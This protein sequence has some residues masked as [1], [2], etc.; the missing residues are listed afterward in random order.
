MFVKVYQLYKNS[1]AGLDRNSWLLALV[2]LVNRSGTMVVPFMSMYMTQHHGV[3]LSKAGVVMACFGVG[4]ITGSFIGGKLTDRHGFYKTMILTLFLGG[5]SFILLSLLNNYYWICFGTFLCSLINEAFRPASMTAIGAY[6]SAENMTRSS[7]LVR[8]SVNLGWALGAALGGWLASYHYHLLFWVDGITNIAASFL[9]WYALPNL[10]SSIKKTSISSSSTSVFISAYKDKWFITFVG[11][12]SLFAICFFQLFTT[13]PV[14]L[15]QEMHLSEA[16]IGTALAFN[17]LIILVFEMV[18]VYQLRYK[19]PVNLI[20]IGVLLTGLSFV[21]FN[22][23]PFSAILVSI[24]S[25][26]II[27]IGEIMSMPFMLT[28]TLRRGDPSTRGQYAALYT[29]AY[30]IAHIIGSSGGSFIADHYGFENLWWLIGLLS[31]AIAL[32]FLFLK[33]RFQA[34]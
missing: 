17:G 1:F 13:L 33:P 26:F 31:L 5:M 27:S 8:Q 19:K 2:Q 25:I 9:V 23:L 22:I 28:I 10:D 30:S 15:K 20:P 12:T 11:L 6:S 18:A 14:Y 7:S 24:I 29:M 21:V 3:S 34:A 16:T 4:S 32:G